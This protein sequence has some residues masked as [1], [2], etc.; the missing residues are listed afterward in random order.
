[1][2][3]TLMEALHK[4]AGMGVPGM[5]DTLGDLIGEGGDLEVAGF[6][7]RPADEEDL[8][9]DREDAD[10][11]SW[12]VLESFYV[13]TGPDT[14]CASLSNRSLI[15]FEPGMSYPEACTRLEGLLEQVAD[16]EDPGEG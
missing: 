12:W 11:Y 10:A 13:P 3:P 9:D 4:Y 6:V 15:S 14:V 8:G 16:D 5:V 2:K 7:F 1:M